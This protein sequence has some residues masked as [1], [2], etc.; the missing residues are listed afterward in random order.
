MILEFVFRKKL[1]SKLPF[2]L[3]LIRMR[4]KKYDLFSFLIN[5]TDTK[6]KKKK[7]CGKRVISLIATLFQKKKKVEAAGIQNSKEILNSFTLRFTTFIQK[8]RVKSF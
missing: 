2:I 4:G 5:K 7:I 8:K 3:L 1:K 6:K